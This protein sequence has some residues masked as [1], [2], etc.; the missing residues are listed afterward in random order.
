MLLCA[1]AGVA[2]AVAAPSFSLS[3]E[4]KAWLAEHPVLRM[5]VDPDY[6]PIE[7]VN[8]QGQYQG[9][10]ADYTVAI[11]QR[12]GVKIEPQLGLNWREAYAHGL[13]GEIDLFG[14]A[15]RT[16]EREQEFLFTE[17]Y[18]EISS[19]IVVR[20]SQLGVVEPADLASL[21]VALVEGYAN[22]QLLLDLYPQL[23]VEFDPT[24]LVALESVAS[25]RAD[26]AIAPL[27]IAAYLIQKHG[28]ANLKIAGS[29]PVRS[30]KLHFMVPKELPILRT[31]VSRA[32]LSM[33]PEE[34]REIQ[35][36][37][38][39]VKYET[40]LDPRKV[41]QQVIAGSLVALLIIAAVAWW[42]LLMWREVQRRRSAE[43]DAHSTA[44]RLA[45]SRLQLEE[46][47]HRQREIT[48]S[49]VG[50]VFQFRL[51]GEGK[52]RLEF[53]SGR[54]LQE[55]G[56][57]P[58]E[59]VG[60]AHEGGLHPVDD[61]DRDAVRASLIG[62]LRTQDR[63]E[64]EFRVKLRD[65]RKVWLRAESVP[66]REA[67][68]H[69]VASGYLSDIT[70]RK[71]MET[72]LEQV[73]ADLTRALSTAA[74][75]LRA[76]LDNS[77][78]AIWA[79]ELNGAYQFANES[80]RRLFDLPPGDLASRPVG[81]LMQPSLAATFDANDRKVLETRRNASFVEVMQRPGGARHLLMVKFPL[82]DEGKVIAIG[83][84]G[85]DITEQIRLQ[86]ELRRL[87]ATLEQRVENRT[88]ELRETLD[89][90]ARAREA[91]ETASRAK[92]EFLANMSHEIRTPMNAI[93]GLSHLALKTD[94]S[95]RQRDYLGKISSAGQS[96]LGLIN[97]ILDFSKIE[98]GKL[99]VEHIEFDLDVVL[100]NLSTVVG[101]K[102]SEKGLEFSIDR[103]ADSPQLFGDPLRLGQVLVNLTNNAVKFTERGEVAVH[104]EVEA[105]SESNCRLRVRVRDTG[106]GLSEEQQVRLFRSFEQADASITRK[107][108]GTGLGLAISKQLVSL[109][110]GEIGVTSE[111]GNGSVFWFNIGLGRSN[112]RRTRTPSTTVRGLHALVVD[113][114]RTAREIVGRYLGSFGIA[115]EQAADGATALDL[116]EHADPPF[117]L[118][119]MDWKMPGTDGLA[120]ARE[121][122]RRAAPQ[123]GPRIIL[124][125]A[126]AREEQFG[127]SDGKPFDGFVLKPVN[128]A[129]LYEKI[130]AA[131]G[132][133]AAVP[134]SGPAREE[135][136]AARGLRGLS[137]LLVEDHPVN[138]QIAREL[139]EG[140]GIRVAIAGDGA[141]ALARID[142]E[143]F[144]VVL[145]DMQMPVMDGLEATRRL[146]ADPR[147]KLLPI[148][149]MT[150][151]AMQQDRDACLAAGM[152]EHMAKP[153]NVVE[154]FGAI[155]RWSGREQFP[156]E[157]EEPAQIMLQRPIDPA[158][159]P[160]A[161]V[162][163]AISGLRRTQGDLARYRRLLEMFV[164]TEAD[165]VT[166]IEAA[167]QRDDRP[168]A[169]RHAHS[170][171]GVA[172]TVGA[173]ELA[174]V[175]ATVE[176]YLRHGGDPDPALEQLE[177]AVCAVIVPLREWL[178][179]HPREE[180]PIPDA[181]TLP[182]RKLLDTLRDQLDQDDT[183]ARDTLE[184]LDTTLGA[185]PARL[186]LKGLRHA[187][188]EY[189]FPSAK[190]ALSS[191]RDALT[192]N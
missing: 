120:C 172:A 99:V 22:S 124:S 24:I 87:N 100:D 151:N 62:A 128:P 74:L 58:D 169:C 95:S 42:G 153:I 41:G 191:L 21:K 134:Q 34:H 97:D 130:R 146:R 77:P 108:G 102:A 48:D 158:S 33:T 161:D 138:Q 19:V 94:L 68:G 93:L 78:A 159:L 53:I 109:M 84:T 40:G 163:D 13:R 35:T 3:D 170:L 61:D 144:D 6:A 16:E 137:V 38:F 166:R 178:E 143:R 32:L 8:E 96:L 129:V 27:P 85:I 67:D 118:V 11:A 90:L 150:A 125:S 56:F 141:Q 175:A 131:F 70:E 121:I 115:H 39:N 4:E 154:M 103:P 44:Q 132:E 63:W 101:A 23:R 60:S 47:A 187:V 31:L 49:I 82:I 64:H 145:M 180:A 25:G 91:A 57:H 142:Q 183:A 181:T 50:A 186:Y 52:L 147:F 127:E 80:F 69:V 160:G 76:V 182:L 65:G 111:P 179:V 162:L 12:L 36:R 20:T 10:V 98:A 66:R 81:E 177:A 26:A 7:F 83:G 113:D 46:S 37:W 126:F 45:E 30:A 171:K 110:G 167:V 107:H 72:S 5:G 9:L 184:N 133:S 43:S 114:N 92:G 189:D 79:R 112:A 122:R 149:A 185:H 190:A 152:N 55:L 1:C 192:R 86:E 73:R 106:I 139:L 173:Q 188:A 104:V 156:V 165:V 155:R 136:L 71:G 148:V 51:D 105:Q 168:T 176:E 174:A 117:D 28:L 2:S 140:A 15:G 75:Q 29:N 116:I 157:D 123:R 88:R 54:L 18:A 89:E 14:S 119:L 17:P 164:H 59:L 135:T